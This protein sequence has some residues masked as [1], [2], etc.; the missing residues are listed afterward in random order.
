MEKTLAI[1]KPDAVKACD[2]GK[3]IN[4]IEEEGFF[5]S[6]MRKLQL[7]KKQA[8]QFYAIHNGK[9]FFSDLIEFMISGPI[10]V[11]ALEKDNAIEEWRNLMGST[12]PAEAKPNT[13]RKLYGTSKGQNATHGSDSP[14]TATQEIKFFF[15]DDVA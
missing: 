1:I 8:E 3:I 11:M 2:S 6:R 9:P 13:I 5:I 15:P 4:K 14:Q 7:S 12:D 10:I